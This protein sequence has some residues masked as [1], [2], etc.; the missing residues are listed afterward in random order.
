VVRVFL[1]FLIAIVAYIYLKNRNEKVYLE[2][3]LKGLLKREQS[4]NVSKNIR[5]AVGFGSCMDIIIDG[6]ALFEKLGYQPPDE[7]AHHDLIE[8]KHKF[9][10]TFAYFMKEGAAAERFMEPKLF[11]TVLDVARTLENIIWR[12][13]GNAPMMGKRL[14]LEGAHEVLIASN[15]SKE[16]M[17][18]FPANMKFLGESDHGDDIHLILEFKVGDQWGKY[19]APRA[20]RFIVHSDV[21]NPKLRYLEQFH[22]ALASFKPHLVIASALQMLDNFP[23]EDGEREK[24]LGVLQELLE[25]IDAVPVHFEMASFSEK[26]MMRSLL[27]YVIP[28][29]TSIGMNEQELPNIVNMLKYGDIVTVA[30]ANPRTAHVLDA[31]RSLYSEMKEKSIRGLER[32]HI[33]TLAFQA[34]LTKKASKWKNRLAAVAKASLV[35]NRYICNSKHV[36][37]SKAKLLMDDSFAV[38]ADENSSRITFKPDEPVSCWDE[39]D[40]ELCVAPVL[41]C[42][43]IYQTAGG[44]DNVSPSGFLLQL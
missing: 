35:A 12:P 18:Y 43:D 4:V 17:S 39:D 33:H 44:G 41:V 11:K 21:N 5:V 8:D 16:Y 1:P 7:V 42:T 24:R 9:R 37:A 6:L 2:R 10:E 30:D 31:M 34:I 32:I 40:Y 23:F 22:E 13:G 3:V 14:S 27:K 20:N 29:V 19:T 25:S 38:S 26:A 28:F 36:D 15:A